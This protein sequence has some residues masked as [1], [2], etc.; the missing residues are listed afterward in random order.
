MKKKNAKIS[1]TKEL[2]TYKIYIHQETIIN[3][4]KKERKIKYL[5]K[6]NVTLAFK[7]EK[8]KKKTK[9]V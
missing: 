2:D 3:F 7:G 5:I 4:N 9:I 6:K 8:E 1:T